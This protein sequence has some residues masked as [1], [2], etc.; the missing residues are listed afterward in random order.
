[1]GFITSI[2]KINSEILM[3]LASLYFVRKLEFTGP[4]AYEGL[5]NQVINA[6]AWQLLA[7]AL[8]KLLVDR[9]ELSSL[10]STIEKIDRMSPAELE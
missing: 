10:Q 9:N 4:T 8:I 1:M 6:S 7:C 5:T 3:R 2:V